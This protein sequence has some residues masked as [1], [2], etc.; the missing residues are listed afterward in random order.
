MNVITKIYMF[1]VSGI[2]VRSIKV[3]PLWDVCPQGDVT[4]FVL[5]QIEVFTGLTMKSHSYC[6]KGYGA[7]PVHSMLFQMF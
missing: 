3:F 2:T 7:K 5:L 1:P 6:E 4:V